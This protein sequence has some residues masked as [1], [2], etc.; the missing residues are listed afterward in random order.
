MLKGLRRNAFLDLSYTVGYKV[1]VMSE[2]RWAALPIWTPRTID[3]WCSDWVK[4]N[5]ETECVRCFNMYAPQSSI[6]SKV[7]RLRGATRLLSTIIF[8]SWQLVEM[9]DVKW[10]LLV[11]LSY[12]PLIIENTI[13]S[14]IENLYFSFERNTNINIIPAYKPL[15]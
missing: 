7:A 4:E 2:A 14:N 12:T 1:R 9:L 11:K 13:I 8:S 3:R 6:S 15:W 5:S 10:R